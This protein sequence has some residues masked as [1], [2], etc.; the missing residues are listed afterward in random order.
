M[1]LTR[2]FKVEKDKSTT[3]GH[4]DRYNTNAILTLDHEIRISTQ[5][6]PSSSQF[7]SGHFEL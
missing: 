7:L 3:F 5:R 6:V 1:E 2:F 4:H